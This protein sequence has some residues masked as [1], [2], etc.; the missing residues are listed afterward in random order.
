MMLRNMKRRRWNKKGR[1]VTLLAMERI[2][3]AKQ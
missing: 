2:V 3:F 1:A